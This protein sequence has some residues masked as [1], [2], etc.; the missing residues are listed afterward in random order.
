MIRKPDILSF[1]K[2]ISASFDIYNYLIPSGHS[3]FIIT[4]E[5][6]LVDII[7][8]NQRLL[9][10]ISRFG[11]SLGFGDKSVAEVCK[12]NGLNTSLV[13]LVLN[14][15]NSHSYS[16]PELLPKNY[17]AELIQY[18]KNGH[19]YFLTS[20]LPYIEE[21][22]NRF[23]EKN[24][25]PNSYLLRN[26]FKEYTNEVVE[27]M[28]LEERTVFPYILGLLQQSDVEKADVRQPLTYKID[29]F[30]D[31]HS[32]IEEKLDD[33]KQLLIK[34]FPPTPD[35]FFRNLILFELFDLD[36]DL[37]DHNGLEERILTPIVRTL[38]KEIK[39]NG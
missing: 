11:I 6:K 22:I 32:N 14:V 16:V 25:N 8:L 9:L 21:L 7:Q 13:L 5:S 3:E 37:N 19:K 17:I 34:H 1:P 2:K 31:N 18:L 20:K 26:F 27:H 24:D 29:D 38:E 30:I 35:Q 36:Y 33:L 28:S 39:G 15:F 4:G 23:I 10:V 12:A